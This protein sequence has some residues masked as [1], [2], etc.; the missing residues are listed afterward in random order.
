MQVLAEKSY[1]YFVQRLACSALAAE[2]KRRAESREQN[3]YQMVPTEETC[4]A[5]TH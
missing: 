2:D 5:N 4:C 3:V 1:L